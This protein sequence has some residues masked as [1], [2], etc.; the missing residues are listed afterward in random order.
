MAPMFERLPDLVNGDA[1]LVRRGRFWS[2]TFLVASGAT[3]HL[4]RVVEGR[5]ERVDRGPFL[6][7]DW[8]FAI[9]ASEEAWKKFWAPV[10]APGY[11]D[12]LAM[13][14][15]GHAVIEGD[16]LVL[17][18]NLRY[19]QDVLSAPRP[20]S[21]AATPTRMPAGH[22]EPIAGR[23]V[24]VALDGSTQRI[25]F[26]EAGAGIPLVCL[27]TA[28]AD[29]KQWRHL[30]NDAEVTRHFRV[31]AFDLPRHGKSLPPAGWEREEYR[32]TTDAYVETIL[33]FCDAL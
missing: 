30:L 3:Q 20:V 6:M 23:Y 16:L 4:V 21:Q 25:Y 28:G 13:A 5:I 24:H 12:L 15:F 8:R 2:G 9:R 11:Q 22:I 31:L 18:Q 14:K 10:P 19:V 32:L 1:D 33:A 7:R 29:G 27:H 26:E 17:M